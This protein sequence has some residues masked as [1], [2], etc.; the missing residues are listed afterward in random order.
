[1]FAAAPGYLGLVRGCVFGGI[2][3]AVFAMFGLIF[4]FELPPFTAWWMLVGVLV[5]SAGILATMSLPHITFDLRERTYR[6]RDGASGF[7]RLVRGSIAN[8]DAVVVTARHDV[9]SSLLGGQRS[10]EF[11]LT[12]HW[13][14]QVETPML[15]ALDYRTVPVGANPQ[16][17]AQPIL[18]LAQRVGQALSLPVY[19]NVR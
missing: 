7:G 19:N 18:Q 6:R 8:L 17:S 5:C 12:L 15:V 1:M 3:A 2:A 14:G 11:Q 9:S 10:F 4:G 13:R 16:V